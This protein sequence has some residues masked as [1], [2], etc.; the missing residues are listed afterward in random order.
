MLH[1]RVA[2][3]CGPTARILVGLLR[4]AGVEVTPNA[5][6]ADAVLCWGVGYGGAEPALNR[7]AGHGNK[8]D[9]LRTLQ[10]ANIAVPPFS[11]DITNDLDFY[12]CLVRKLQHH[13]GTDIRR[14]LSPRAARRFKQQGRADYFT[15]RL[16]NAHEYRVW[17]YRRK[18]LGTYEKV[19]AHPEW[20]RHHRISHNHRNGYAFRLCAE[21]Q[22][23][24]A[25]VELG[26]RAIEALG[27][28]FGAVDIIQTPAGQFYVLEV[29]TAPGVCGETRQVIQGLARKI[30]RWVELKFPTR[31]GDKEAA[32][33]A[34]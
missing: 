28:D 25:A 13:G 6:A 7:R 31:K 5:G 19:L 9:E 12:P 15:R 4:D 8:L 11:Q 18:H 26:L 17:G 23:P 22:I 27:L 30:A 14:C 32:N 20:R 3:G 2:N 34:A 24:R 29:N 1:I 10:A 33:E 16:P 21:A